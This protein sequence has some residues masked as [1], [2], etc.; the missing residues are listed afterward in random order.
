MTRLLCYDYMHGSPYQCAMN[1]TFASLLHSHIHS[2]VC[3]VLLSA[4]LSSCQP[5]A[6]SVDINTQMT[7]AVDTAMASIQATQTASTPVPTIP[8]VATATIVRTPPALASALNTSLLDRFSKPHTYIQDT[9]EY[10]KAKWTST[11]SP[12]GTVVMVIMIH[13]INKGQPD[14]P[15]DMN[16]QDFDRLMNDLHDLGFQAIYMQELSD[17]LYSNAKIPER[18]VLLLQDDRHFAENFTDHFLPYYEQW[19]WPVVNAWIS[20]PFSGD[21]LWQQQINLSQQG[22]VDYEAHGV[23]HLAIDSSSSDEYIMGE[24]QGSMDAF[25]QHFNKTPIAFIW[26]GGG[27]TPH[28]VQLARSTGYKLGFTVNPR[29]PLMY[30]WIPLADELDQ[31]HPLAIPEGPVND[32]LMVLPRYWDTNAGA[33]LDQVRQIGNAAAEYAQQQKPT[34]LEYYDIMCVPNYGPMP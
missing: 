23:Q 1:K 4:T 6:P 25:A 8:A 32:P 19:G 5:A 24:L 30:N 31:G 21:D 22:W 12:P 14:K 11:N 10:L 18:S 15:Q 26:P 33:Y 27:F 28:A 2:L 20:T 34:E 7:Q 9:C 29:G 13:G 16:A 3:L 17:F